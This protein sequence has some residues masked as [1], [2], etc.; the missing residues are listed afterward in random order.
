MKK[1]SVKPL[2]KWGG[3][4][5]HKESKIF[6]PPCVL[7]ETRKMAVDAR[8]GA[9]YVHVAHAIN[10]F[11]VPS[12]GQAGAQRRSRPESRV[13]FDCWSTTYLQLGCT[14]KRAMDTKR[15]LHHF[16]R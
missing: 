8:L 12:A 2:R 15:T 9:T 3:I 1:L 5:R 13:Q 16:P 4:R 14:E 7:E 6:A 10:L 11:S